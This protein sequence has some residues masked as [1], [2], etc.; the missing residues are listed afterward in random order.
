[1]IRWDK[2]LLKRTRRA[3]ENTCF[4]LNND[5]FKIWVDPELNAAGQ[6]T[7]KG[8]TCTGARSGTVLR[9]AAYGPKAPLQKSWAVGLRLA[10]VHY[11][12]RLP[13]LEVL[14]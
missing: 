13:Q 7:F 5:P 9:S 8:Q 2:E 11:V 1:V 4:G 10:A 3:S 14:M 12:G 6:I